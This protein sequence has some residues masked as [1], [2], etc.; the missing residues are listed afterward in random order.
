M[1]TIVAEEWVSKG[2]EDA[3][4]R[5]D[6]LHEDIYV[7]VYYEFKLCRDYKGRIFRKRMMLRGNYLE[8]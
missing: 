7:I 1:C 4:D 2:T 6:R 3:K 5:F 8:L